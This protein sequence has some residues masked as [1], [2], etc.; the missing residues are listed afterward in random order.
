MIG[1][2]ALIY[3]NAAKVFSRSAKLVHVML[4]N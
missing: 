4:S 1:I 3:S 2:V